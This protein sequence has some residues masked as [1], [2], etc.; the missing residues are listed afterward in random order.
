MR[1][2]DAVYA[3][4]DRVDFVPANLLHVAVIE[5]KVSSEPALTL[6]ADEGFDDGWFV[7]DDDG[8]DDRPRDRPVPIPYNRYGTAYTPQRIRYNNTAK[9]QHNKQTHH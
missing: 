1:A 7:V 8:E 2:N 9:D 3:H 6:T 5:C 4:N